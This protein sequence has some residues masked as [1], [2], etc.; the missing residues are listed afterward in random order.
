MFE[1][2]M[3]LP[4]S[5]THRIGLY[6]LDW[7]TVQRSEKIDVIKDG[8]VSSSI[9]VTD[10]HN[11]KYL[12]WEVSGAVTF[13]MSRISGL[14]AVLSGLFFDPAAGAQPLV[15]A[16]QISPAGGTFSGPVDLSMMSETTGAQ[17]YYTLDGSTPGT[18]ST[19]YTGPFALSSSATV[20]ARA[21]KD[22]MTP[23]S[24]ASANFIINSGGGAGTASF[25]GFDN[26]TQGTWRGTYGS[27]G[28]VI[29]EDGTSL[30]EYAS[31]TPS[32]AS[33][34]IWAYGVS[35]AAA[36]QMAATT[37]R[38]ASCWYAG[39][40]FEMEIKLSDGQAHEVSLYFLDWDLAGRSE[41]V[42]IF[43]AASGAVLDSRE[44]AAFGN[45]RW[46]RWN[47]S[48]DVSVRVSRI[49]GPNAVVSG[50]FFE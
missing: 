32:G 35:E 27:E 9:T 49:S 19:V 15:Q 13:R 45:G 31:I 42:E 7:D 34:H 47:V 10:F 6:C 18:N 11:G 33:S 5:E 44:L 46:V 36:L 24:V 21:F 8:V 2:Q 12:V 3:N 22:G 16:P 38:I 50:M 17:I 37:N 4:A 20:S 25:I 48:G 30:P 23:S 41:G 39:D 14:N 40:V 29:A 1:I 43:D 28:Y 26:S